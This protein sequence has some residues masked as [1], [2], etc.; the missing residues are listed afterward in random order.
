VPW[1]TARAWA[2]PLLASTT[3]RL[4]Q[5]R[6][7][8]LSVDLGVSLQPLL[9]A[10]TAPVRSHQERQVA[11]PCHVALQLR[12]LLDEAQVPAAERSLSDPDPEIA[13]GE[14]R[15][16]PAKLVELHD[17]AERVDQL[18]DVDISRQ[19]ADYPLEQRASGATGPGDVDDRRGTDSRL[20]RG[21]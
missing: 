12:D 11:L 17:P 14:S 21:H 13:A 5:D 4:G 2:V 9:K 7:V 20:I 1:E 6:P 8:E 3:T 15:A 10:V 16:T 19:R 18:A